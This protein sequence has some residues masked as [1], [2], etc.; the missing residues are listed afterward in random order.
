MHQLFNVCF[1]KNI[2]EDWH[3][4]FQES[5]DT[6]IDHLNHPFP[7]LPNH[8]FNHVWMKRHDYYLHITDSHWDIKCYID[9]Y[10]S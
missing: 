10:Y 7:N 5:K 9:K 4:E 6:L 1:P 2:F 3:H 8:Q